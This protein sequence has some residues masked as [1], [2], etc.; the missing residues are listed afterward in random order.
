MYSRADIHWAQARC[1][2]LIG[3]PHLFASRD[4]QLDIRIN[5]GVRAALVACSGVQCVS[6]PYSLHSHC[7]LLGVPTRLLWARAY[8]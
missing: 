4:R 7:N 3:I 6:G 1:G 8:Y 2:L 5:V